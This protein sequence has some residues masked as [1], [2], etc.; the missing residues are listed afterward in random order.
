MTLTDSH[1]LIQNLGAECGDPG[2]EIIEE[3]AN[4]GSMALPARGKEDRFRKVVA[5]RDVF[6]INAYPFQLRFP[7]PASLTIRSGTMVWRISRNAAPYFLT[8]AEPTPGIS[9]S[10]FSEAARC[11]TIAASC[12]FVNNV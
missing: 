12:S 5:L 2:F 6:E 8:R 3:F 1:R 9:S 11:W 4:L 10:T 7:F